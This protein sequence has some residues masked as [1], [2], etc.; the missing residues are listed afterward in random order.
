[1]GMLPLPDGLVGL[2]LN[3]HGRLVGPE[4]RRVLR[5]GGV[6][7]TQQVG[8]EDCADLNTM[9]G[10]R[11]AHPPGSWSASRAGEA[12]E[13]AGLRLVDVREER[14]VITFYD[15]GAVVFQLRMVAWQIP[16]FDPQ[17]CELPLRRLHE[18]IGAE[19]R[20]DFHAHRFL[21]TAERPSGPTN[22]LARL[23]K[24]GREA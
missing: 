12:L 4:V 23:A 18:R 24:I 20:L 3:R 19:G 2:V 1:M 22:R 15:I 6:L 16:D 8:S 9:L 5:P 17:R 14:P 21:I 11:P 7:F 13:A 10:A